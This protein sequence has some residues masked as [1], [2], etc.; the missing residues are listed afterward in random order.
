MNSLLSSGKH[1]DL[2]ITCGLDSYKVHK[3]IVCA[4]SDFFNKAVNFPTGK[5]CPGLPNRAHRTR[6][7]PPSTSA[8]YTKTL[9]HSPFDEPIEPVST[10]RAADVTKD[11]R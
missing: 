5:V 7:N 3:N 1:S 10:C 9:A 6:P 11:I 8:H 4:Q 2:V